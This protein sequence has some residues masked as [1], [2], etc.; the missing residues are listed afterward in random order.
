M[1]WPKRSYNKYNAVRTEVDGLSFPSKLE[2]AVYCLLKLDQ[3]IEKIERQQTVYLSSAKISFKVDFKLTYKDGIIKYAEAKGI[4]TDRFSILRK[5]W[6]FYGKHDLI[7]YKGSHLRPYID[8]IITP[9]SDS[10]E[11]DQ[12]DTK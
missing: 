10:D 6:I 8:E 1:S 4:V 3:E 12:A 11:Q 9:E 7:I 5:L 2:G